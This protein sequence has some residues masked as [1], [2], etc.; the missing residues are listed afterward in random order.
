MKNTIKTFSLLLLLALFVQC[1]NP[2]K[3][4][5]TDSSTITQQNSQEG[6]VYVCSGKSSKRYHKTANCRG[7]SGCSGT[8]EAMTFEEAGEIGKTPCKICYK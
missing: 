4:P 3:K 7:L 5:Q 8:V 6:N 1:G 2:S